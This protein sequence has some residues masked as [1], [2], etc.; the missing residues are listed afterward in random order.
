MTIPL[1]GLIDKAVQ[2]WTK[3]GVSLLPPPDAHS[4]RNAMK[5]LDRQVSEDVFELY[6]TV[7]G[8]CGYDLYDNCWGL[9]S[10]DRI[11]E[12]NREYVA[13]STAPERKLIGFA[14]VMIDSYFFCFQYENEHESSVW[15]ENGAD[16]RCIASCLAEFLTLY[17][18]D[19]GK[20][21]LLGPNSTPLDSPFRKG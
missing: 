10:L 3:S 13:W 19:P 15:V 11:I 1:S 5:E 7:G 9:W 12:W 17:L 18:S 20:V 16:V 21:G 8:F 2:S 4:I 14:D 6:Q